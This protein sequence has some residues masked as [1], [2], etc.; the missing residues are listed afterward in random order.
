MVLYGDRFFDEIND[1]ESDSAKGVSLTIK[2]GQA[3]VLAAPT[4][5]RQTFFRCQFCSDCQVVLF[6]A[7]DAVPV[8]ELPRSL[9]E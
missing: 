6:A 4:P 8:K 3:E 9:R 1:F 5:S 2:S 7:G